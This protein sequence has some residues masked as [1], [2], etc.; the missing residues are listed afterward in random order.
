MLCLAVAGVAAAQLTASRGEI[1]VIVE[2]FKTDAGVARFAI[3]RSENGFPDNYVL[4]YKTADVEI[5]NGE[6]QVTFTDLPYGTYAVAVHHDENGNG[7][8]DLNFF[9]VP[10]EATG[11][12]N[13]AGDAAHAAEFDDAKITL[14]RKVVLIHID[15]RY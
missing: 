8:V 2:N 15:L 6:A 3:F 9:K 13:N 11:A 5:R 12:S 14:K 4:A 1:T 10:V 7:I